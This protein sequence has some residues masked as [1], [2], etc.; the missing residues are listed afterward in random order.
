MT[1]IKNK[2][3]LALGTFLARNL[4]RVVAWTQRNKV[5]P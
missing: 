2:L 5:M 3:K 4:I 1:E